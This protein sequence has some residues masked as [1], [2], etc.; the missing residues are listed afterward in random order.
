MDGRKLAL[1]AADESGRV[2]LWLRNLGSAAFQPLPQTEG[3]SYPFW[4]PDSESIGFVAADKLRTIRLSDGSVMTVHD[5]GFRIGTW[6]R[7]DRIL[8][9]PSRS[10]PLYVVP[11]P[12]GAPT[13]V[14]TLDK[15]SGEVQHGYPV[16]LPDGRHF[17]YFSIGT[18]TGGA[19]D[20]RGIFV[21]SLDPGEPARLLAPGATQARNANGHLLFVLNGTLMA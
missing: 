15:A 17:L 14:T 11:A 7:D 5:A 10:S 3:A 12:G 1:I 16:F 21:G 20:P 8:F 18:A 2:Q 13:A 4:S 9:T 19:L 6:G